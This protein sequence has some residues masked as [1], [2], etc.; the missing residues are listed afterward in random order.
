M[1]SRKLIVRMEINVD[2]DRLESDEDYAEVIDDLIKGEALSEFKE[3]F[4]SE[5]DKFEVTEIIKF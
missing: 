5:K 4:P 2:S 3:L 1:K